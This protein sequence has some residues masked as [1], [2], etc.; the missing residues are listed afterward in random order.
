VSLRL[1]LPVPVEFAPE[2]GRD[3]KPV[4]PAPRVPLAGARV[5]IV[6]NRWR[7]MK[8]LTAMVRERA[9]A[10]GAE[11]VYEQPALIAEPLPEA[12]LD[13]LGERFDAAIVGLGN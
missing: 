3:R 11:S 5:L 1:V 12:V 7:S 10:A 9:L 6:N 13:D 8:L 2:P 4:R